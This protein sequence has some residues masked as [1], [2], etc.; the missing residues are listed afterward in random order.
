M[1]W[2]GNKTFHGLKS[3]WAKLLDGANDDAP[4]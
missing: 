3:L 2:I 4:S 1:F